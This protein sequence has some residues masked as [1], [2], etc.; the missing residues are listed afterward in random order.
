MKRGLL[1][2]NVGTPNSPK[3]NDVKS[4]L[5]GFLCD[6]LVIQMPALLRQI[7][8]KGI[9]I[10]LRVHKSS[11]RYKKLWTKDGSPLLIHLENLKSKL[12]V[13]LEGEYTVYAAMNYG[14]PNIED[15][16]KKIESDKL[17]ELTVFPLF[18]HY[19]TSTTLSTIHKVESLTKT[20]DTTKV[21]FIEQFYD[22]PSF[23]DA[24]CE[25]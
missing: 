10:P 22:R 23:I 20:W 4:Y 13:K 8:V 17:D 16:L 12:Q 14:Q 7:L 6:P 9:I 11:E 3:L 19:T 21:Q 2:I 5:K 24:V 15:I 1:L 25:K 18:P